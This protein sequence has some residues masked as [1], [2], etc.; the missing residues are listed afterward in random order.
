MV[1][2]EYRCQECGKQFTQEEHISEHGSTPPRCPQCEGDKVQ[3]VP[4][5]IY[6]KTGK[7]S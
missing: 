7:K 3:Q 4:S 2:Y 6:V 5:A 1:T